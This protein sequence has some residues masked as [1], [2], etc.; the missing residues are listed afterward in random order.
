MSLPLPHPLPPA[1][2]CRELTV[3]VEVRSRVAGAIGRS[4]SDAD[5]AV[6]GAFARYLQRTA[7]ITGNPQVSG[8]PS[9]PSGTDERGGAAPP[10]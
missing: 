2:G 5:R 8:V 4:V 10:V 1:C 7:A 3:P 9:V 6:G